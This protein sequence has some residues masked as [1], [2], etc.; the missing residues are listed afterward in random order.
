MVPSGI[1]DT[2]RSPHDDQETQ[3][4]LLGAHRLGHI[5]SA[6]GAHSPKQRSNRADRI[7]GS[8]DQPV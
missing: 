7:M 6:I 2:L 8:G 3:A 1:E 4:L 5:R